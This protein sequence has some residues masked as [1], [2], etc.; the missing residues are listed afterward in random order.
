MASYSLA[1]PEE[2]I[3]IDDI[4]LIIQMIHSLR[5]SWTYGNGI[6]ATVSNARSDVAH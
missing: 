6:I 2:Y 5:K 1:V 4:S 3:P